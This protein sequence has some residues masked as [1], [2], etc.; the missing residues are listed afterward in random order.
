[1]SALTIACA[2]EGITGVWLYSIP[3]PK[4]NWTSLI[5]ILRGSGLNV[6]WK[7]GTV[8]HWMKFSKAKLVTFQSFKTGT[9]LCLPAHIVHNVRSKNVIP[10]GVRTETLAVNISEWTHVN[11]YL[12]ISFAKKPECK[13]KS[14]KNTQT[15]KC[16]PF[17]SKRAP[18]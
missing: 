18:Q 9:E 11:N 1:M 10:S 3:Y 15:K 7:A 14:H 2:G 6:F 13:W 4:P 12:V 17:T 8:L 5:I 16:Y